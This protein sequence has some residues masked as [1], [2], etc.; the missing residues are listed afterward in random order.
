MNVVQSDGYLRMHARELGR[1]PLTHLI[2]SLDDE[3]AAANDR[4]EGATVL[5]GYTEW[6]SPAAPMLSIGW[7]W[8][9]RGLPGRSGVV[10]LGLP[11]T[12]ILL[13]SETS[14]P[15]PWDDSLEALAQYID[16]IDWQEVALGAAFGTQ[17]PA[18]TYKN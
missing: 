1:I 6:V 3:P 11:R 10:R 7:D 17:P 4:C 5:C 8:A 9:W 14:V 2:S 18:A 15:L 13:V 12:N 16:G